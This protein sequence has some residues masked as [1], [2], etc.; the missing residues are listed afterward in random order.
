MN[1]QSIYIAEISQTYYLGNQKI[2]FGGVSV[3]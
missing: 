2:A 3:T 1:V